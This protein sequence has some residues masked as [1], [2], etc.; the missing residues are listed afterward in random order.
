ME[1]KEIKKI[2]CHKKNRKKT[3]GQRALT[4]NKKW[5]LELR[6]QC[7]LYPIGVSFESDRQTEFAYALQRLFAYQSEDVTVFRSV[8]RENEKITRQLPHPKTKSLNLLY[9]VDQLMI[10]RPN[11]NREYEGLNGNFY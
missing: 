1:A 10:S 3:L 11:R 9:I 7:E 8:H 6:L 2:R 4:S 5:E